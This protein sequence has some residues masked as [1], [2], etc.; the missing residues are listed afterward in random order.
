MN[1]P[2]RLSILRVLL[3]PICI[4][5]MYVG[6][7]WGQLVALAVFIVA[8]ITDFFDG[9][10]ARKQ[11]MIT[12][13]G[14][15]IDPLADKVL[16]L[17]MLVMLTWQGNFWPWALVVI[18]TRELAVDGLRMLGATQGM[19]L[20]AG[21]LGKIKTTVQMFTIIVA[22]LEPI[23]FPYLPLTAVLTLLTVFFTLWS[24]IDYFVKN[25]SIFSQ[26][27]ML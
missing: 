1:L 14:K 16:V 8:A 23:F 10:I 17:S 3:I 24:G 12:N 27:G 26:E 9:N 21:P 4:G 15:F 11:N 18:L 6:A 13:F 19:V 5:F 22:I 7:P 2:N 20:A 25:K